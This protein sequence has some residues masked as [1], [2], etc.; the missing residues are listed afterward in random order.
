MRVRM[1]EEEG[2]ESDEGREGEE[3][4]CL[5]LTKSLN[6]DSEAADGTSQIQK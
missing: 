5:Y 3:G 4:K 1:Y 2:E 6:N